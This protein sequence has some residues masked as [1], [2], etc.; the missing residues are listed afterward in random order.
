MYNTIRTSSSVSDGDDEIEYGLRSEEMDADV[1][2][3]HKQHGEYY[4]N[5]AHLPQRINEKAH[6]AVQYLHNDYTLTANN[7]DKE[8]TQP[9]EV[10]KSKPP[11]R[12]TSLEE[13]IQM[14][15]QPEGDRP[16]RDHPFS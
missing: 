4:K 1:W 15:E 2:R 10:Y 7:R 9:N 13:L 5:T 16:N 3:R 11:N 12:Y 14:S 8:E 6:L